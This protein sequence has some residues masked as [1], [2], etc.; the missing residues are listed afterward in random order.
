M[1]GKVNRTRYVSGL[2]GPEGIPLHLKYAKRFMFERIEDVYLNFLYDC[3]VANKKLTEEDWGVFGKENHHTGIP[4]R[5]GGVLTPLNSQYLTTYQHWIAGV[6]QSELLQKCC[7]A[8]VPKGVLPPDLEELR[9]KWY[10]QLGHAG[11]ASGR[12]CYSWEW[13]QQDWV[14]D[15]KREAA[16]KLV[17]SGKGIHDP[18]FRKSPELLEKL[19]E[20]GKK[21]FEEGKGIHSLSPEERSEN[22]KRLWSGMTPEEKSERGRRAWS[23]MSPEERSEV[24]RRSAKTVSETYT[25]WE[26]LQ[27]ARK[28]SRSKAPRPIILTT[29]EGKDLYYELL[30][31]ACLEHGLSSCK[32]GD[33]CKGRRKTHKGF[34]A[35]YAD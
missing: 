2:G 18:D 13:H 7:F 33:M 8:F 9:L 16:L 10:R 11:V 19:R 21:L 23:G 28:I 26:K 20:S 27:R 31:D 14:R 35:R 17:S 12:S 5:D 22:S 25:E 24:A 30:F 4:S 1:R 15:Y 32:V 29:P 6:L 34:T 3:H